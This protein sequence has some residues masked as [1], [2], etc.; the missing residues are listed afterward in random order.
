MATALYTHL[1]FC[2]MVV[3]TEKVNVGKLSYICRYIMNT[4]N[5]IPTGRNS[6]I[7]INSKLL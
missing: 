3:F 7:I 4:C 1:V 6:L 5:I 2:L